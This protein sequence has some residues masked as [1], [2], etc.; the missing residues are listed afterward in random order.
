MRQIAWDEQ[1]QQILLVMQVFWS[2][3]MMTLMMMVWD[4]DPRGLKSRT[5]GD[6]RVV[7]FQTHASMARS[8]NSVQVKHMRPAQIH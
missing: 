8:K 2:D 1:W 6:E 3:G 7:L 4:D 5:G